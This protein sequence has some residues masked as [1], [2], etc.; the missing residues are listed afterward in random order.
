MN[1]SCFGISVR[2]SVS[3]IMSHLTHLSYII[4]SRFTGNSP[5]Q[6]YTII[7]E[8]ETSQAAPYFF[9][10][11]IRCH[12]HY[13]HIHVRGYTQPYADTSPLYLFQD[14]NVSDHVREGAVCQCQ[15]RPVD[16][17]DTQPH[18]NPLHL[19]FPLPFPP[20]T[21]H[22]TAKKRNGLVF[23]FSL[24]LALCHRW[25]RTAARTWG[26]LT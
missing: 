12:T 8:T 4:N 9:L 1:E 20:L 22:V 7:Y 17:F 15:T 24:L 25:G 19:F 14:F 2:S 23:F 26:E 11:L 21:Q 6:P 13:T 5:A 18:T 16:R 3:S 10:L